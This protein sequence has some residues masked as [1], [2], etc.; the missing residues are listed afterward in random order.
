MTACG[1]PGFPSIYKSLMKNEERKIEIIG[2]DMNKNA[3]GFLMLKKSYI[4]PSGLSKDFIPTILEIAERENIDV[5]M[6]LATYELMAFAKNKE[7]FEK[8]GTKVL[9]SNSKALKVANNKGMLYKFLREKGLTAPRSIMV[10]NYKDFMDATHQLGFPDKNVCF[11]PQVGRGN[12]GIRIIK[13]DVNKLEMLMEYKP[14]HIMTTMDEVVDTFKEA[15]DFPHLVVMEELPGIEYSVDTLAKN[16]KMFITIPRTRDLIKL[17]ISVI[18]T[19]LNHKTIVEQTKQIVKAVGLDYNIGLQFKEDE[20]GTPKII[21]INPRVQGTMV[22]ATAS[23]V[24]LPYLAIK[25]ALDE[26][27]PEQKPKWNTKMIRYWE[28]VFVDKNGHP[29]TL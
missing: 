27:I 28:E 29:F 8:I 11:K 3:V 21:E 18:G 5:I 6:P 19:T 15:K 13:K 7:E 22:L 4:V 20:H 1:A 26:E 24:N 25:L 12:R 14:T 23:G 16:G 10:D 2:T 17:G 9:V